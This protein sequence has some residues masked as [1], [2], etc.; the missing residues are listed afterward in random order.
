MKRWILIVVLVIGLS[1]GIT[2]ALQ[3]LPMLSSSASQAKYLTLTKTG[4]PAVP[5]G[6]KPKMVF[7][8]GGDLTYDFGTMP[9]NAE[10]KH[11]W[12]VKNEGEGPL[13]LR[14]ESSTCSCTIAKFKNGEKAVIKPGE[15]EPIDLEFETRQNNGNYA[16]G[17]KIATNDPDKPL[18]DLQ[19]KG[20]VFP[21]VM[22][23]PPEPFLNFST[24][25]N[26][27]DE[28]VGYFAVYSRDRPE[29]KVSKIATSNKEVVAEAAQ[30]TEDD[31]KQLNVKAATKLTV[32]V[33]S[34]MPLGFFKEEVVVSTDHPKQPE[35]RI[36]V[37]GRM[38][39]AITIMP[40][41]VV[42]HQ[43]DGRLG[44]T[45]DVMLTVRNARETKFEIVSK[46]EGLDVELKP[47][48]R[49]GRYRLTVKVPAGSR[50]TKIQDEIVLK[51]D[52]PKAD[53]V[54][55]PVS[56]FVLNAG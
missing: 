21:P 18:F 30:A 33:K 53:K 4:A 5:S 3:A 16:K 54:I 50:S 12:M 13:E 11:T 29:T 31:C 28:H 41:T 25:S 22:T 9:Q 42:M 52:H 45:S 55:V 27:E 20:L 36:G 43:A 23:Y 1:A 26:D 38:T 17:A 56:I 15:T 8:E 24:I 7:V 49:P 14:M 40:N 47:A 10:G 34:G 37:G 48:D 6:P 19:V 32:K 35:L 44:S 2:C 46:P 51:T 39:G